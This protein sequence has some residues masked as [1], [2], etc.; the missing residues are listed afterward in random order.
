MKKYLLIFSFLLIIILSSVSKFI[1]KSSAQSHTSLPIPTQRHYQTEYFLKA[2]ENYPPKSK[3]FSH[4]IKAAIIPHHLFPDFLLG[5]F[6]SRL[7]SQSPTTV[8]IIGPNHFEKGN[9]HLLTTDKSWETPFGNVSPKSQLIKNLIGINVENDDKT[10]ANDH[11]VV[12]ILPYVSHYLPS[13][14][15]IPILVSAHITSDEINN[16]VNFLAKNIDENTVVIA[17][18][19]FSHNLLMDEA[20]E[21]DKITIEA[22]KNFDIASIQKMG[23]DHLDSPRSIEILLRTLQKMKTT[24]IQLLQ[25]TNSGLILGN[26]TIPT[27]SYVEMVMW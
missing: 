26:P 23:N 21:K 8:F 27:T 5:D 15:I 4:P 12:G 17:A 13:T 11:A 25:N 20:K 3:Q 22:I 16:L 19:D 1:N 2:F 24:N 10:L 6:F 7:S 14:K 9:Q 18:V